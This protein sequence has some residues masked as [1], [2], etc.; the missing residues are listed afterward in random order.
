MT[1]DEYDPR[2]EWVGPPLPEE[3]KAPRIALWFHADDY[4]ENYYL[5]ARIWRNRKAAPIAESG[6]G[7]N[8]VAS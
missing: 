7:A 3:P 8:V 6:P 1:D 5:N 4:F 2:L